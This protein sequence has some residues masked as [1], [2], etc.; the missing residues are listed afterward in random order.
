MA[1]HATLR[2][3][4]DMCEYPDCWEPKVTGVSRKTGLPW[5]ERFC[6]EHTRIKRDVGKRMTKIVREQFDHD[7]EAWML[8]NVNYEF[9]TPEIARE[10][11]AKKLAEVDG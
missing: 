6:L 3:T 8:K 9:F 2:K 5:H 7:A 11:K 1:K 10:R 4:N